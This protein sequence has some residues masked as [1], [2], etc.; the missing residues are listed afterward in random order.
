MFHKPTIQH[1]NP[2]PYG[3]MRRTILRWGIKINFE[4]G[5]MSFVI[6]FCRLPKQELL[7]FANYELSNFKLYNSLIHNRR[8]SRE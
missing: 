4:L 5:F 3:G 8:H 7:R 6:G 2:H 1:S